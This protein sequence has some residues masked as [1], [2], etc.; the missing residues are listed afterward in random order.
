MRSAIVTAV[1]VGLAC[2]LSAFGDPIVIFSSGVDSSGSPLTPGTAD[3]HYTL[4]S[5]PSGV[6]LTAI[7][8]SPNGAWAPN[9]P[10]A[11]WIS[12]GSSGGTS[13]PPGTYDYQTTF[14]LSGLDPSTAQLSGKW[15]SDNNGCIELNGVSTGICSAFAGFASLSSFSLT[16]GF[17]T[18]LN[19]LDFVIVNGTD[20]FSP[21]GVIAE[22]SGTATTISDVSGPSAVPEPSSLSMFALGAS[23][24]GLGGLGR[25][26]ARSSR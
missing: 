21:T 14:D 15:T 22:V 6:V 23:L 26:L 3:S 5:A 24:F 17:Q 2:G 10:T 19:T 25:K 4:V 18:G 11:D 7:A 8:T 20:S 12:P 1:I 16:S 13:F 9:T